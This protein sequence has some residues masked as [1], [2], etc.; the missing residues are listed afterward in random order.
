M[1][2]E[3]V[4][5]LSDYTTLDEKFIEVCKEGIK[6]LEG[7][8][9]TYIEL[10]NLEPVEQLPALEKLKREHGAYLSYSIRFFSQVA[11][12]RENGEFLA[13][14]RKSLKSEC[15]EELIGGGK[16]QTTA[17]KIVYNYPK[18]KESI[19]DIQSI[20]KFLIYVYETYDQHKNIIS[21]NIHQSISV[22]QKELE[23]NRRTQI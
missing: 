14:E 13:S 11:M 7:F 4:L 5:K 9:E 21:R 15:I 18:Y 10:S 22:L 23:N 12:Y 1:A 2:Q 17:E 20:R 3:K 6:K 8:T 19:T 16:N